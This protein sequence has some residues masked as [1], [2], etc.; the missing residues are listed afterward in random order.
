M[1]IT[2]IGHTLEGITMASCLAEI[3]NNVY[4]SPMDENEFDDNLFEHSRMQD[5]GLHSFFKMQIEESRINVSSAINV[6][7]YSSDLYIITTIPEGNVTVATLLDRLSK[8]NRCKG[9]I[10][11]CS[12]PVGEID[13]TIKQYHLPIAYIPEFIRE[14]R[15]LEDFRNLNTLTFGCENAELLKL[16]LPPKDGKSEQRVRSQT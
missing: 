11:S 7:E 4:L 6:E 16:S 9:I 14:G 12:L 2:V 10:F 5:G 8:D 1:K 15:A 13:K 3:G